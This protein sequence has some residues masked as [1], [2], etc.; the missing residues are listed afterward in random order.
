M[1]P[2]L[3]RLAVAAFCALVISAPAAAQSPL[4]PD[5]A[6]ITVPAAEPAPATPSALTIMAPTLTTEATFRIAQQEVA[7]AFRRREPFDRP[8]VLMI[9][10][11]AL[12]LTGIIVG[13]DAAPI[14]YL[15][16]AGIGGYGLYLYLQSPNARLVR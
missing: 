13:S 14:L 2:Y 11:G 9:V 3:S 6:D 15:A 12:I 4:S 10:G 7:P 8:V 1:S 5:S 16:G